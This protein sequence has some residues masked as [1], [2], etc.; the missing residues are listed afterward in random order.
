MNSD[1]IAKTFPL[2][3]IVLIAD[4]IGFV[5]YGVI[6]L[7]KSFFIDISYIIQFICNNTS[8]M[9]NAYLSYSI[10][11]FLLI[12]ISIIIFIILGIQMFLNSHRT[13]RVLFTLGQILVVFLYCINYPLLLNSTVYAVTAGE[14]KN[15]IFVDLSI[16]MEHIFVNKQYLYSSVALIFASTFLITYVWKSSRFNSYNAGNLSLMGGDYDT[17]RQK[18]EVLP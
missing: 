3:Q 13:F 12:C 7:W 11:D 2:M 17:A 8:M 16:W 1:K 5:F 4:I 14:V 9:A 15:L 10:V 18:D 6:K